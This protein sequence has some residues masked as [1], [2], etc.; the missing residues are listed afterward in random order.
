MTFF[1]R[2]LLL[3]ALALAATTATADDITTSSGKKIT[4]K[5][6]AIDAQ[7]V[8]FSTGDAQVKVAGKDIVVLDLHNK[9]VPVP[10]DKET[11]KDMRVTEIELVDGS[12]FRA[13]KFVLKGKKVETEFFPGPAGVAAPILDIPM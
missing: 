10:K 6:V 5:L 9:V 7:G 3:L 12:N 11:G 2:A 8:T 1:R 4:G 13:T